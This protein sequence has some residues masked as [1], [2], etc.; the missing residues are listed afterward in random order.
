MTVLTNSFS[1]T[2][3]SSYRQSNIHLNKH[4]STIIFSFF[5]LHWFELR[6]KYYVS[7]V[8]S[9]LTTRYLGL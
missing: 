3:G 7:M 4:I 1:H 8:V 9:V 5:L 2:C 6:T